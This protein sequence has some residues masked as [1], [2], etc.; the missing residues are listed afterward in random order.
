M[1]RTLERSYVYHDPALGPAEPLTVETAADVFEPTRTTRLLLRAAR[2][3]APAAPR[4]GL[5]L[6]CGCG[7]VA[8][9]LRRFVLPAGRVGASD[10]SPSAVELTRRNAARLGLDVEVR[11]GSLFE[12]WAGERFG[13]IVDDVAAVAEPIA[14]RSRWYPAQVPS[15]AG[16]EGTRWICRVL[17]EAPR[18][19]EPGG[20]LLF[21][22]LGLA[23][24][25]EP[26][27]RARRAFEE[28]RL[29]EEEWYPLAPEL[30]E[31]MDLLEDLARRGVVE[32]QR[33]GSRRLWATRVYL[34]REPRAG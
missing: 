32:L 12:P 25:E 30:A 11:C 31:H 28:V 8:L 1:T 4:S 7:I 16:E 9:A 21:P 26:L 27:E 33:R 23:G 10:L 5:D 2:R 34:A 17:E 19:L 13:L 20:A 22:L 18:H 24:R 3:H 6:G 15:D 29:V 14:R